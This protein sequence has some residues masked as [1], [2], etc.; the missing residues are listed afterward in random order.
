MPL[1]YTFDQINQVESHI[2]PGTMKPADSALSAYYR[3]YLAQ[4]AFAIY[5]FKNVPENWDVEYI[6]WLLIC[7]GVFAVLKTDKFGI[8]PQQCGFSGY[9]VYYRPTRAIVVN[10]LFDKTYDLKIGTDT[11][12]VR[13]S[14]DW[15]GIPDIIGHYADMMAMTATSILT[16]L[17]NTRVSYVF[18]AG[19]NAMAESFKALY[20]KIACGEPAVFA[21]KALFTDE[22]EPNWTAFNQD[23]NNTYIV[24]KLQSAQRVFTNEFYTYLGIP[25]VPFEKNERLTQAESTSYDYATVGLVDLWRRTMNACFEKVNKM[26]GHNVSV[27]F[28]E[29]LLKE[30][31]DNGNVGNPDAGRIGGVQA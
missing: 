22:G 15:R 1:P 19:S 27:D 9:N 24:D 14:P 4:R 10:P 5:D 26:F 28:N 6:K 2:V 8:I 16:N 29:E 18:A 20:D 7:F 3:R 30:V 23:I 17:Y 31:R 21:D 25:N 11:E 12:L 13:L